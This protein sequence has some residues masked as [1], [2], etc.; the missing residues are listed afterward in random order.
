MDT[1]GCLIGGH[2][3]RS[4]PRLETMSIWLGSM[5]LGDV[6]RGR[7]RRGGVAPLQGSGRSHEAGDAAGLMI[8]CAR[9]IV[10]RST[11]LGHDLSRVTRHIDT[12]INMYKK[13]WD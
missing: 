9:G 7:A 11:T 12:Y 1:R 4:N 13:S 6:G 3:N 8:G 10:Y 2:G 5:V